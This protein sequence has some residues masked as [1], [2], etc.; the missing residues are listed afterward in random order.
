MNNREPLY[1]FAG[2]R[3]KSILAT[4][5][6]IGKVIKTTGK[7]RPVVAVVGVASLKDN[8][9][10]YVLMSALIKSGCKCRTRRVVIARPGADIEKAKEML[11]KADAVF[12]SGGDAEI[13][14]QILKEKGMVG[15]FR[16]LA[17]QGKLLLGAS[18]GTIMMCQEWVRWKDPD[19]DS[20]AELYPCLGLVPVICDTHAE[21]DEWVELKA[22]LRL[23]EKGIIGYGITSGAC[24][25]AF[26]YGRL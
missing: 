26:P 14:M 1:L 4:F 17:G 6:G 2:G 13:G 5:S 3:G 12:I 9:L 20:T 16:E 24:L 25:K 8:I 23:A 10:I 19:D 11:R 18:A 7:S 15:F 21:G 22:A